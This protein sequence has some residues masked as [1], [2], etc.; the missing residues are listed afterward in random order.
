MRRL[1]KA[2]RDADDIEDLIVLKPRSDWG[3][4]AEMLVSFLNLILGRR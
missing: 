3:L 2:L 1:R 4:I